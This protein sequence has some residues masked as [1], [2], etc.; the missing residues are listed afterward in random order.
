MTTA[1]M[2]RRVETR[3]EIDAGLLPF[4]GSRENGE[5]SFSYLLQDVS[6][7]GVGVLLPPQDGST[8]LVVGEYVNFHLPFQLN[9]R[10][11]NQGSIR[12]Q[13]TSARGQECGALLEKRVPLKY[14]VYVAFETADVRF[15]L[16]AHGFRDPDDLVRRIIE[17]AFFFK[18][19]L[20]IYFDHL[21][22]LL[23]RLSSAEAQTAET[24]RI[25]AMIDENVD[26]L[27]AARDQVMSGDADAWLSEA[28]LAGLRNALSLELNVGTTRNVF[29]HK[30]AW[31][32]LRSIKLLEHQ[33]Y[34]SYNTLVLLYH[35]QTGG[36]VVE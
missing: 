15:E 1:G 8:P 28:S 32:Y 29:D 11:Y 27:A 25:S 35:K 13:K 7:Q 36:R 2:E 24:D 6:Q 26:Y 21:R 18:R 19:G 31:P 23:A 30:Q 3:I 22:P 5:P 16:S 10:F 12:W 14:P 20:R 17:D 34:S 4:L 33:L 9:Q